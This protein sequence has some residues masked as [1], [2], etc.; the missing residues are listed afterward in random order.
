V[1][2]TA[3]LVIGGVIVVISTF[4]QWTVTSGLTGEEFPETG[5]ES[6]EG[7]IVLLLGVASSVGA[8]ILPLRRVAWIGSFGALFLTGAQL[9]VTLPSAV[10]GGESTQPSWGL[11]LALLGGLIAT[12]GALL[13]LTASRSAQ[14][15]SPSALR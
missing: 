8:L 2:A 4:Q 15:D 1:G 3:L 7:K 12:I 5:I 11:G 14:R 6:S 9:L 13:D 10:F